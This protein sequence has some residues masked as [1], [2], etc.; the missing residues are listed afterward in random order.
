MLKINKHIDTSSFARAA[1]VTAV[2]GD[3][4]SNKPTNSRY[5]LNP[6]DLKVRPILTDSIHSK[7]DEKFFIHHNLFYKNI[8]NLFF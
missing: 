7:T 8:F 6:Y 1:A 3:R 5:Y 4:H 2:F